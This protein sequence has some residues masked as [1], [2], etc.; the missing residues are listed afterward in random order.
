MCGKGEGRETNQSEGTSE[1]DKVA[2][3]IEED[4]NRK[5]GSDRDT[6]GNDPAAV[7]SWVLADPI[8]NADWD[9]FVVAHLVLEEA[10]VCRVCLVGLDDSHRVPVDPEERREEHQD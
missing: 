8:F 5:S 6:S 7:C 2:G 3:D 4:V 10:V 1:D 9:G